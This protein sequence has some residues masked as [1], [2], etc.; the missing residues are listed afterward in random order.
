[1]RSLVFRGAELIRSGPVPDFWRA[2]TDNDLGNRMPA[3]LAIWRRAGAD[4]RIASVTAV[5]L[6]P[7]AVAVTIES[8]LQAGDSPH[9]ARYTV[10]GNGEIEA[11]ISFMPGKPGLPELP[12]FGMRMTLPAAFD[13]MTWFGRGPHESYWDRQSGAAVGLYSGSVADQYH[14][15]V[16]PQEFGNKT[17][18]RWVALT[19]RDGI[20]L[21]AMGLPV[22]YAAA[23][24]MPL[25]V[26]DGA[27]DASQRRTTDMRPQDYVA[28]NIDLKQMG[29]GGD[30]SWGAPTHPE[31][32]LPAQPY[33][34]RFRLRP[35][36][37][38]DA[39]PTTLYR[40]ER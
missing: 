32:T 11:V 1:M 24:Q 6:S 17:D 34:Y 27:R 40:R 25:E 19:N 28:L 16:R 15:Y 12:R 10:S 36:S 39:S 33:S 29:V 18:V 5:V 38:K 21:L 2:P 4:R 22:V 35:F 37:T 30:T 20:G 26:Y 9:T 7:T 13:T 14:P 31:Y 8:V 23:T 3:R